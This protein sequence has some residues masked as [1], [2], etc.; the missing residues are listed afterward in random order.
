[1]IIEVA[2]SSLRYDCEVKVPLYARH[3]IPEVWLVDL[4]NRLLTVYRLPEGDG[5][6]EKQ[7]LDA[8]GEM[9]PTL[10]PKCR[11]DFVGLLG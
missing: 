1:L 2:D 6:C 4:E 9:I 5:Y 10:L 3:A 11:V 8:P 7:T